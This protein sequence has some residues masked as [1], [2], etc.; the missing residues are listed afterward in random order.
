MPGADSSEFTRFKKLTAI[1]CGDTQSKDPK[2]VNRLT[3]YTSPVS[4]CSLSKFLPSLRKNVSG[5]EQALPLGTFTFKTTE[6][7]LG[8]YMDCTTSQTATL[9]NARYSGY[10]TMPVDPA[11]PGQYVYYS[12][13][14]IDASKP[15]TISGLINLVI[16]GCFSKQLTSLDVSGLTALQYLGC[17]S[18]QLK[19]LD[20]SRLTALQQLVCYSNQLTR[21]DV[22]RLTNLQQLDCSGNQLTRLDVSRLTALQQLNCGNNQLTRLDVSRLTALQQLNCRNN[23]LNSLNVSDTTA[24]Q[25][26]YCNNNS[27]PDQSTID[28]IVGQLRDAPGENNACSILQQT[29]DLLTQNTNLFTTPNSVPPG[30][31][32]S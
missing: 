27:F 26:L 22:S 5:G 19:I 7:S 10:N 13:V 4:T 31:T 23:Q 28:T 11:P 15:V 2:S 8:F 14:V 32:I 30:W 29:N 21:L 9:T 18:N 1:Q 20:V 17:A 16:L 24:L 6:N 12:I 3:Q 25:T